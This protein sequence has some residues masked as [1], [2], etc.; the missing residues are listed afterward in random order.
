MNRRRFM[1]SCVGST[2][3]L[4]RQSVLSQRDEENPRDVPD[5]VDLRGIQ[6]AVTRYAYLP[7]VSLRTAVEG[8]LYYVDAWG[9]RF[10]T[11]G[12][13]D[14]T[15]IE[16]LDGYRDWYTLERGFRI[17]EVRK[18]SVRELGDHSFAWTTT[19]L[20]PADE[21]E[22]AFQWGMVAV[23]K[24][25]T[26]QILIGLTYSGTP[27]RP[28]ADIADAT[29]DRWPNERRRYTYDGEPAGG[30]WDTLPRLEDLEEGMVIEYSNDTTA[31]LRDSEEAPQSPSEAAPVI[32]LIIAIGPRYLDDATDCTTKGFYSDVGSGQQILVLN[33]ESGFEVFTTLLGSASSN[34]K[35]CAWSFQVPGL[36]VGIRY[37]VRTPSHHV[38]WFSAADADASGNI[39]IAIGMS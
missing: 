34:D 26:V 15:P 3:L 9:L 25:L 28:L 37:E 17:R 24:E 1:A 36:E 27:I 31:R 7:D 11:Q 35:S 39:T 32:N 18:A 33:A 19:L 13:A 10:G 22:E 20:D 21:D 12:Q 29:I 30:I 2:A 8:D 38:G 6:E 16:M 4:L 23:Q 5:F 14:R